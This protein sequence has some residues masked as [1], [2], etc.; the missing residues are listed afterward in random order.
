MQDIEKEVK[1]IELL[2]IGFTN[3]M[4]NPSSN[5]YRYEETNPPDVIGGKGVKSSE[6]ITH[7]LAKVAIPVIE[8]RGTSF[9]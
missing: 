7:K 4:D 3:R 2:L 1:I 5:K 9:V 8:I 6:E